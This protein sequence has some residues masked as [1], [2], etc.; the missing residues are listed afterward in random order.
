MESH[1]FPPA[2]LVKIYRTRTDALKELIRKIPRSFEDWSSFRQVHE[3]GYP[4]PDYDN[5]FHKILQA[6]Q[7]L[8]DLKE[9]YH[10]LCSSNMDWYD[11]L[12]Q[13]R[14]IN[15]VSDLSLYDLDSF[16]TNWM[17]ELR[18]MPVRTIRFSDDLDEMKSEDIQLH[19]A[20]NV[21]QDTE[22]LLLEM[23]KR[24]ID[25]W[26][27]FIGIPQEESGDI[28]THGLDNIQEGVRVDEDEDVDDKESDETEYEMCNETD[29]IGPYNGMFASNVNN[30]PFVLP[31]HVD[32]FDEDRDISNPDTSSSNNS[33]DEDD[34]NNYNGSDN[35]VPNSSVHEHDDQVH[36]FSDRA[37]Q[38]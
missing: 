7:H 21:A 35:D 36:H 17:S 27:R 20:T 6:D 28:V 2:D 18:E 5:L 19:T 26:E 22:E 37:Q 29:D 30:A 31:Y 4:N 15:Q 10:T 16:A 11:Q 33:A 23:D 25:N 9:L 38:V 14:L 8:T 24:T 3:Y 13:F 1:Y 32:E 12:L 34:R